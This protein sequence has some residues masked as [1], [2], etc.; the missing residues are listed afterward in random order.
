MKD[1]HSGISAPELMV[2]NTIWKERAYR[3][4]GIQLCYLNYCSE[5]RENCLN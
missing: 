3:Q 2:V 4:K 1:G 5:D